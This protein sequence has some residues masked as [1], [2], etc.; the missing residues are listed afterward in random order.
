[1]E[2]AVQ[3]DRS[4]R[5]GASNPWPHGEPGTEVG[6][7]GP[8][9][10]VR[11]VATPPGAEVWML[12]G[13]G[14]EA[15]IDQLPCDRDLDVLIAGPTTYRKK[16]HV[17]ASDFELPAVKAGLPAVTTPRSAHVSAR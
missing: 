1:F 17:P 12:V 10:T 7:Q 13:A 8:P 5:A 16:L 11:V 14:P 6:G 15:R 9:G 4:I 2:A 3:L